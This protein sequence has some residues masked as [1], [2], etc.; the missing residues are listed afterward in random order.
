LFLIVLAFKTWSM[1]IRLRNLPAISYNIIGTVFIHR[2]KEEGMKGGIREYVMTGD[3]C[4][5]AMVRHQECGE[6]E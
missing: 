6:L 3:M 1:M 5:R 2:D 4:Q